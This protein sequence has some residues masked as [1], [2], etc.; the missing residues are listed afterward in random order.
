MSVGW[1]LECEDGEVDLGF[2]DCN[3]FGSYDD[4]YGS[5]NGC[6]SSGCFSIETT[7]SL[8]FGPYCNELVWGGLDISGQLLSPE[9]QQSSY[10][11]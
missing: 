5:Y 4:F 10:G 1:G 9:I 2:G 3:V 11:I 6:M 8:N 7:T